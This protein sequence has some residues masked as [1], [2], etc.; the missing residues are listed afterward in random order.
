MFRHLFVYL[1]ILFSFL[2]GCASSLGNRNALRINEVDWPLGE[3]R[4]VVASLLPAGQRGMSPNGRELLS[5]HFVLEGR[6]GYK[7]AGDATER[8]FAQF[9][10]LGDRRPYDVEI[11]VTQ[12]RRVLRGN[13]F[14][15]VVTGYDTRLAKELERKLRTELTKRREDRNIIDDFRVY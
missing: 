2:T 4:A 15:Y 6:S 13:Q 5:R 11:L 8:Y 7:P 10:I 14:T 1:L 3:I 12:E 9:L